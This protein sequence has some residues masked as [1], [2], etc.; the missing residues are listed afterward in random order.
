M[1]V[2][3]RQEKMTTKGKRTNLSLVQALCRDFA[4]NL[5]CAVLFLLSFW[6]HR[7]LPLR[8]LMRSYLDQVAC[9]HLSGGLSLAFSFRVSG[10]G[11]LALLLLALWLGE[12]P[13]WRVWMRYSCSPHEDQEAN[14]ERK[15]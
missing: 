12:N 3:Q 14:R 8:V 9:R 2:A 7:E 5:F 6:L 11:C 1:S 10:H 13:C 15:V 4:R